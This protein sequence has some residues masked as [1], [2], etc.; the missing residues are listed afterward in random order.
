M[1]HVMGESCYKGTILQRNY[2]K[3]TIR[4]ATCDYNYIKMSVCCHLYHIYVHV[5]IEG[6]MED[7]LLHVCIYACA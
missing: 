3:M 1:A 6:L 2:M 5:F 4:A 7:E